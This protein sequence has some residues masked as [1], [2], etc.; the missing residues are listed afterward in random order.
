[1]PENHLSRF[2]SIGGP[3]DPRRAERAMSAQRLGSLRPTSVR[4]LWPGRIPLGRITLLVGD[5]GVGKSLLTLDIAARVSSGK[6]WPD[7]ASAECRMGNAES[8]SSFPPPHSTLPTSPSS[9]L[10]FAS[11]DDLTDTILP[12]LRALGADCDRILAITYL[13][14]RDAGIGVS[15]TFAINR[16]IRRLAY[17]LDAH[18]DCRLIVIDPVS[19]YLGGASEFSN[20]QVQD[21]L[22]PLAQLAHVRNIAVVLVAHLRK[23]PGVALHRTAGSLAFVSVARSAWTIVKDPENANRRLFLPIK[24]NIAADIAGLAFTIEPAPYRDVPI[25]HWSPDPVTTAADTIFTATHTAGRPD[26]ER[27]QAVQWL[28]QFL[29]EGP[30]PTVEIRHAAEAYGFTYGT[31]RRAFRQL[32]CQVMHD[33]HN[34]RWLWKLNEQG[35]QNPVGE[36]C[37]PCILPGGQSTELPGSC[38]TPG[39]STQ[40]PAPIS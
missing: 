12:R 26:D 20:A 18:P 30:V 29:A 38:L 2:L 27:Q 3:P 28:Q 15:R 1:M 7:E 31:L 24:S 33:G 22:T 16:D 25:L 36:L 8:A 37:A 32:A 19:A 13:A 10:L 6:P 9:V 40:N 21:V 4:W 35:A 5:P 14:D 23:K 34:S 39:P 11:E 17:L